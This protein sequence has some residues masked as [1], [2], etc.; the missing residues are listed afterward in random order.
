MQASLRRVHKLRLRGQDEG[1]LGDAVTALQDAFRIASLPG[2]PP[3]G[4]L[5]VRKLELGTFASRASSL[6]LSQLIDERIRA[7]ATTAVCVDRHERPQQDLVWFSD[8]AQA[9]IRLAELVAA[10]RAP[11]AWYWPMVFPSWR[12]GMTLETTLQAIASDLEDEPPA[13]TVVAR[14]IEDLHARNSIDAIIQAINPGLAQNLLV[15]AGIFSGPERRT[16][17][18]AD[19]EAHRSQ[20][21]LEP[22]W[23]A[24]IERAI[25]ACGPRD[26]R[27]LLLCYSTLTTRNPALTADTN[28]LRLIE[29]TIEAIARNRPGAKYAS[30]EIEASG[31]QR[32]GLAVAIRAASPAQPGWQDQ[33]NA[34]PK[35]TEEGPRA[36]DPPGDRERSGGRGEFPEVESNNRSSVAATNTMVPADA[37][38]SAIDTKPRPATVADGRDRSS[39]SDPFLPADELHP[40]AA[41]DEDKP[42]ETRLAPF[43]DLVD[44]DQCGLMFLISLLNRLS[45][46]QLL[47]QNPALA[48]LNFPA[49]MIVDIARRLRVSP[50]H[51]L[52]SNLPELPPLESGSLESFT[53]PDGW[54]HLI[55]VRGEDQAILHRFSLASSNSRFFITDHSRKL[56]LYLGRDNPPRW[57]KRLAIIE[58]ARFRGSPGLND[59]G[60]TMQLLM[61]RYLRRFA[62]M[63]LRQLIN[64]SGRLASSKTHLDILFE[65]KQMDIRIRRSGLDVD[66]GWVAW[67]ARVVQYHYEDGDQVDV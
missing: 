46:E 36:I 5:L 14:V 18:N 1:S 63:S 62:G 57:M 54:R 49:R 6:A 38:A 66:P 61:S 47:A 51:P 23:I 3:H 53:C 7:L 41:S 43:S 4:L 8:P 12:P 37:L 25:A 22:A 26:P 27:T 9:A 48:A 13:H 45:I 15:D 2:I 39:V 34:K 67:L 11:D 55:G 35:Q 31:R 20:I 60:R 56:L 50:N 24:S 32:N 52:I 59:L 10:K 40:V 65:T 58:H 17:A 28:L 64:R 29:N 30:S 16:L 21:R 19:A 33:A 44:S 42:G